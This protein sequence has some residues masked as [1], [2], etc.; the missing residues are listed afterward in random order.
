ML[1]KSILG[2][3]TFS[4]PKCFNKKKTLLNIF[5][6]NKFN[7]TTDIHRD[8]LDTYAIHCLPISTK[9]K[10]EVIVAAEVGIMYSDYWTNVSTVTIIL[11]V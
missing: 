2:V 7:T 6:Q 1:R 8:N 5:F 4:S 11:C 3:Q 10:L 9:I